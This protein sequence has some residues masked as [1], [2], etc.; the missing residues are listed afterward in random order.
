MKKSEN[1]GNKLEIGRVQ[2]LIRGDAFS[3]GSAAVSLISFNT[4]TPREVGSIQQ[5]E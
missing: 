2:A 3:T 5:A 1:V 4:Q